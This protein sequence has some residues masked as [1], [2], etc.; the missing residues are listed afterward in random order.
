MGSSEESA[1]TDE[2]TLCLRPT[3]T[4]TS[5]GSIQQESRPERRVFAAVDTQLDAEIS[6]T[7][8]RNMLR[9]KKH[10][11]NNSKCS[12]VLPATLVAQSLRARTQSE[13]KKG[14]KVKHK[15]DLIRGNSMKMRAQNEEIQRIRAAEFN[16]WETDGD[17]H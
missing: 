2:D 13:A 16:A 5:T 10:S 17:V 4:Q 7:S 11:S 8:K 1:L 12:K 9:K 14:R 15:R 6:E 3:A